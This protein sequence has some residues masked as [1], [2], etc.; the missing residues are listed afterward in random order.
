MWARFSNME[1]ENRSVVI[2]YSMIVV[3][4]VLGT[5]LITPNFISP[6]FLTQQL[7]L[8]SFLGIVVAGQMAVILTGNIDLSIPWTITLSAVLAT[9]IAAGQNDR[10]V[11]GAAAGIGVGVLVGLVNGIGVAYLRIP[12]MVLTLGVNA[13]LKGITV[14]YTGSAPQFQKTPELLSKAATEVIFGFL[15]VALILW[16]LVSLMQYLILSRSGLGR[17]TYAV[18]NNEIAAYLSGIKTPRV[19]VMIFVL[20]GALN[21]LAGLLLAGNAGRSFNEM[22]DPFLLPAIAAVVVG[23]T[24]ILGGSGKYVGTIAGV[25]I[26]RLLDG[27][28]NIVQVPPAAKDITFGL[29]IL[30][31][32][33]L[34]GR[35]E[36]VRE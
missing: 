3:L 31:M 15:P 13:V 6:T 28:L 23:G 20:N 26:I 1:R 36:K 33:F 22:G 32:L 10:L 4:L 19:L 34:Y 27:A 35:G 17:K 16:A 14:V 11:F 18:G 25:I 2:S 30:A 24:S 5:L 29:V 9:S 7:R 21:A 12:S 8:A